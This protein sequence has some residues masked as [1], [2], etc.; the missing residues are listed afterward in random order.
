ME[1]KVIEESNS[2]LVK[3]YPCKYKRDVV[4]YIHKLPPRGG[5]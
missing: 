5:G 2:V 4:H 3:N 1:K